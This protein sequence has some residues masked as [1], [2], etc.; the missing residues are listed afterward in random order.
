MHRIFKVARDERD[1]RPH[2]ATPSLRRSTSS[3]AF[4]RASAR[5]DFP[6]ALRDRER[7]RIKEIA[8]DSFS[9]RVELK[10]GARRVGNAHASWRKERP[11]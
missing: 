2:R 7:E 11:R 9:A 5:E 6:I 10:I 4:E 1:A 3:R 8:C